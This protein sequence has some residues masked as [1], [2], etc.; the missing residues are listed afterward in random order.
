MDAIRFKEGLY[1]ISIKLT[2][3]DVS[4]MKFMLADFLPRQQLERA[5][6][7]FDVLCLMAT[8][9]DLL[10]PKDYSFLEEV[11]REVGKDQL[12]KEYLRASSSSIPSVFPVQNLSDTTSH[13]KRPRVLEFKRFL[14]ELADGLS[15]E[16][17]HDIGLFFADI[18]KSINYQNFEDIKSGEVL[19]SKLQESHLIG[20]GHLQLLQKIFELIGR[21]DLVSSIE[22]YNNGFWQSVN[23]LSTPV[24]DEGFAR[25]KFLI[26]HCML[27]V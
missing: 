7:G 27:G 2:S 19:F 17:I 3:S 9:N 21:L 13:Y 1:T 12:V 22:S 23:S 11:L 5:K 6:S 18:C 25:R 15:S 14:C 24:E 10:S 20:V 26:L 8:R 16:N 4:K